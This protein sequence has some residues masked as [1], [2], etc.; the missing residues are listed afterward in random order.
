MLRKLYLSFLFI[1]LAQQM[2]AHLFEPVISNFTSINYEA[3]LQNWD[4]TQGS[5]GEMYFGNNEGVLSFDGFW[6]RKFPLPGNRVARSLL[7]SGN[8]LYVGSYE[9]FGYM[10]EDIYGEFHYTSLWNQLKNYKAHNDEIWNIIETADNRI[11]FQSFCSWFE[12]DGTKVTPHY[13]PNFLPL[14]FFNVHGHTYAQ[15][16]GQG[17][18][19][20]SQGQYSQLLSKEQLGGS[21]VVSVLPISKKTCYWSQNSMDFSTITERY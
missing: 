19:I 8:R 12:Y 16:S 17:F 6:W 4:I 10:E 1:L 11:I 7:F 3:G 13:D 15:E 5:N 20:L 2:Q 9:E 18:G 21:S 14:Y